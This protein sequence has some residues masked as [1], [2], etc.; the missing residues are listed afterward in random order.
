M[1]IGLSARVKVG[2]PP[3]T[4]SVGVR[5]NNL[6]P[7]VGIDFGFSIRVWGEDEAFGK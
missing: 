5:G 6:S 4:T 2:R 7:R 1:P 3:T